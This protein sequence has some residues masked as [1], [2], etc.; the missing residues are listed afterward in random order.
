MTPK[1]LFMGVLTSVIAM[2][3]IQDRTVFGIG[4]FTRKCLC[5]QHVDS[6]GLRAYCGHEVIKERASAKPS[7]RN[8]F[9]N[10]RYFCD[11]GPN[12]A[13]FEMICEKN[14]TCIKGSEAYKKLNNNTDSEHSNPFLRF[15]AT[16]EGKTS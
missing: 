7:T 4:A 12:K 15:C 5:P 6:D 9:P 10:A 13:T 11:Y 1:R 3:L 14:E 16:N 8:C 2:T